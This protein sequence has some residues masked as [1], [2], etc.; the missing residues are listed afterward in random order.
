MTTGEVGSPAGRRGEAGYFQG[1][2]PAALILGSFFLLTV[3][4][5]LLARGDDTF[6][7]R[8]SIGLVYVGALGISHFVITLAVYAQ[9]ANRRFFW[10]T[11]AN[12]VTYVLL[13]VAIFV[14]FD[15]YH[16]L[17]VAAALPLVD[18]VLSGGVRLMDFQHSTRQTFG[19]LQLFRM[20]SGCWFPPWMKQA[21]NHY[22]TGLTLLLFVTFLSG[23]RF[24][25][26]R[27][28]VLI[29]TGV[30][31]VLFLRTL[32][33]FALSWARSGARAA[34][35][36]P[37]AYLLLQTCSAG[38][39]AYSTSL[40][41][42][43]LAM[44]YV[45]YHV[46]MMP[47]CFHTPLDEGS[48]ADRIFG[49]LRRHRLLFYALVLVAAVPVTR[50]AWLGMGA[51]MQAGEVTMPF[52][53]RALIAVFDG[54]FVLHYLIES[55]IWKFGDPYYRRSLLP[56]YFRGGIPRA[57]VPAGPGVPVAAPL[58]GPGRVATPVG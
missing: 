41:A 32:A 15:L 54:L 20:R 50:F 42:F 13:P 3:P 44:H 48:R 12:R 49:L 43:A 38:L 26:E 22:F 18:L 39:A 19:V 30:V 8:W 37:L 7:F 36:T 27:P 16:A 34:L 47:R 31:V 53:R 14:F 17:G 57:L 35:L 46:L 52:S 28:A 9:G 29:V 11:P 55:R 10:S 33:G 58:D 23:G 1:P 40:Y 51:L 6:L 21:E 24:R 25:P 2:W 45:E 56:L 4:L 5:C